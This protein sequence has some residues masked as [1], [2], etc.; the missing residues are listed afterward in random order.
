[1]FEFPDF[2]KIR[3]FKVLSTRDVVLART[4]IETLWRRHLC[5]LLS[6]DGR[7]ALFTPERFVARIY[8]RCYPLNEMCKA[9]V[10]VAFLVERVL[11]GATNA[12][13]FP[14]FSMIR[15]I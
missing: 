3:T 14:D 8:G 13:D 9:C 4:Q 6:D 12:I 11:L 2:S 7:F 15:I 5:L 10:F 1:M